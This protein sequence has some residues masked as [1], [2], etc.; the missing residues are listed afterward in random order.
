MG[1]HTTLGVVAVGYRVR[2][3]F[4]KHPHRPQR[5]AVLCR[6]NAPHFLEVKGN[7][8]TNTEKN[9]RKNLCLKQVTHK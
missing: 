2:V 6:K 8:S 4:K 9:P 5:P 7:E 1:S 3:T